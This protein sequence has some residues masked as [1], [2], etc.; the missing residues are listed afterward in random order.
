MTL[1]CIELLVLKFSGKLFQRYT[2]LFKKVRLNKSQQNSLV[3]TGNCWIIHLLKCDL[4]F[5]FV[6]N[7]P[8][9]IQ[10]YYL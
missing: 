6:D 1:C 7:S 10:Y 4:F 5:S 2:I 3:T 8:R 9:A